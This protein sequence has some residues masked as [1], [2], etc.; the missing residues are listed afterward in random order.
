[1]GGSACRF[2]LLILSGA[3]LAACGAPRDPEHTTE[4]VRT[5][6]RIRAGVTDNPPWV[7]SG[8]GE[9][10]GLE[11]DL[12]RRFAGSLG[13]R[14]EWVRGSEADLIEKLDK[15]ELDLVAGGIDSR[16]PWK[17]HAALSRPYLKA[18]K[19][20][21]VLLARSGENRLV[22]ELDR[23]LAAAHPHFPP[24]PRP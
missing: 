17:K 24:E 20:K 12:I 1:M 22:L 23:Y 4:L 13:A 15:G 9:P 7:A 19:R 18:G 5:L 21:H 3:A 11:P 14:V 16:T 10:Q 8:G 2:V 6:H